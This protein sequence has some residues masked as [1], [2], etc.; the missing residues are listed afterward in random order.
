MSLAQPG[1]H[2]PVTG[3]F[4]LPFAAYG[5]YLAGRVGLARISQ[6][7]LLGDRTPQQSGDGTSIASNGWKTSNDPLQQATRAHQNF[8]EYVPL[9]LVLAG[10]AELNGADP[11]TLRNL[12]ATL[13]AAR[14][15]HADFG[16]RQRDAHG[17]G[18]PLGF[19]ATAVVTVWLGWLSASLTWF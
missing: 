3:F 7:V 9:A 5:I 11:K 18:R 1:L 14:V 4:A 13:L 2:L 8:V 19:Y 10:V 6:K 17:I 16:L 12:L 15:L